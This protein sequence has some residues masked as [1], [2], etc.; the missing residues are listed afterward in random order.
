MN[1]VRALLPLARADFLERVRRPSFLVT[2]GFAIFAAYLFLPPNHARYSTFHFAGHRGLYGSAWVGSVIAMLGSTFLSLAGFYLVK[3]AVERDRRTGVGQILAA[4][5]LPTP[6]YLAGKLASNFAV[7]AAMVTVLAGSAAAMQLVRAEEAQLRPLALITPFVVLTLPVMALVAGLAVLFEATPGLRGGAGN[8]VYFFLW[9]SGLTTTASTRGGLP[10][11][12]GGEMLI[13]QM[14]A[15]CVAAFPDLPAG[16]NLSMGF[17]IRSD[18]FWDLETFTWPG[19]H[20]TP[21][22]LA[23]RAA[24]VAVSIA[25]TMAAALF[26]DRFDARAGVA[27]RAGRTRPAAVTAAGSAPRIPDPADPPRAASAVPSAHRRIERST[28]GPDT[29]VGR[30]I[31]RAGGR[32]RLGGLVR[33]ELRIMLEGVS[34]WWL[35]VALAL[36]VTSLFVPLPAVRGFLAPFAL[37]WPLLLWSPMGTR[38]RQHRTDALL[39]STPRPVARLLAAQWLA[40]A[41]LALAAGSGALARFALTGQWAGVAALLVAAVFIPSLALAIG[42]WSGSAKLFEVLYLMLWYL[43]PMNRIPPLDYLG[44]TQPES[45]MGPVIG[46]LG[47][48]IVLAALALIGRSRQLRR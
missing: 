19:A 44:A 12:L 20:W 37:V 31:G 47:L 40:G 16:R 6:L 30:S 15:A 38:E 8:V 1:A 35:L 3:N 5:P 34:R 32:L 27:R 46:F 13:A 39:F 11:P 45:G 17:N 36:G 18:G 28:L 24:W 33:A 25:L 9:I 48:T 41:A 4:T 23:A 10:D 21:G 26:F 29:A 43:G 22:M 7:L 2:L 14:H 42:I